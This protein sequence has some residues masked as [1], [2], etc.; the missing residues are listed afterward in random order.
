MQIVKEESSKKKGKQCL[1]VENVF[2]QIV[3]FW[4]RIQKPTHN[5]K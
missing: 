1:S 4:S 2:I 3:I 5:K